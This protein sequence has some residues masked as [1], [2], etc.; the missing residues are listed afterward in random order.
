MFTQLMSLVVAVFVSSPWSANTVKS[1]DLAGKI[2]DVQRR[3]P[4]AKTEDAKLAL[5]IDLEDLMHEYPDDPARTRASLLSATLYASTQAFEHAE[6][7]LQD[8]LT[9]GTSVPVEETELRLALA[10]IRAASG[11]VDG[12][13]EQWQ[14]VTAVART[15]LEENAETDRSERMVAMTILGRAARQEEMMWLTARNLSN[16]AEV[17]AEFGT[18]A[19]EF[20]CS[21]GRRHPVDRRHE[22]FVAANALVEAGEMRAMAGD[23]DAA[24]DAYYA[25]AGAVEHCL[26]RGMDT[27]FD[28]LIFGLEFRI[29]NCEN[30]QLEDEVEKL[31]LLVDWN[32]DS[33][34][35]V[36]ETLALAGR[37]PVK[38]RLGVFSGIVAT[39][40]SRI[41]SV[42]GG[43]QLVS[44]FRDLIEIS[45][46]AGGTPEVSFNIEDGQFEKALKECDLVALLNDFLAL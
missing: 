21:A 34:W 11:D 6:E 5:A 7:L 15:S 40:G 41:V 3:I 35:V 30:A 19:A 20:A 36:L 2:R 24:L 27:G 31:R 23:C 8:Q 45:L 12:A 37:I 42:P 14:L 32:V 39:M 44:Q 26:D 29:A 16:A 1:K 18:A 4:A 25:A 13:L 33:E 28:K 17:L 46:G 9:G 22:V 43:R 10:R 38:Q